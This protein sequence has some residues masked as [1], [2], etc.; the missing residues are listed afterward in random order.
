[1]TRELSITLRG[2][3]CI[4]KADVEKIDVIPA[5]DI[6]ITFVVQ[7]FPRKMKQKIF[8]QNMKGNKKKIY[9]SR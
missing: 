3:A 4:Y 2:Y 8:L 9:I 5:N 7:Q 1:M 6:T